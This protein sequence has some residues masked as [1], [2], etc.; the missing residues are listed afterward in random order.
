MKKFG[1]L[2]KD[3][4]IPELERRLV[5]KYGIDGLVEAQPLFNKLQINIKMSETDTDL[6]FRQERI[7]TAEAL[8]ED[9]YFYLL[10]WF[11]TFG[12]RECGRELDNVGLIMPEPE[13]CTGQKTEIE[14]IMYDDLAEGSLLET[15]NVSFPIDAADDVGLSIKSIAFDGDVSILDVFA[16]G[17]GVI[18]RAKVLSDM[19]EKGVIDM[20]SEEN[21]VIRLSD[22]EQRK[23]SYCEKSKNAVSNI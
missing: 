20:F 15:C 23:Y 19:I 17:R 12:E 8:Q 5:R 16:K 10:D 21:V 3:E 4:L 22:G 9:I 1:G 11:K 7:S 6:G 18:E 13:I 2:W 14:V